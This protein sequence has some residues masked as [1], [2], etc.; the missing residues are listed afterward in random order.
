MPDSN[1]LE[2]RLLAA[3]IE[4]RGKVGSYARTTAVAEESVIAYLRGL[5]YDSA[6]FRIAID[7]S[8]A[9]S[10]DAVIDRREVVIPIGAKAG[11]QVI[12]LGFHEEDD[13]SRLLAG[14]VEV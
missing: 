6:N 4:T 12:A 2:C 3:H 7:V 10:G 14:N 9:S 5:R 8:I 1:K 13:E 11:E